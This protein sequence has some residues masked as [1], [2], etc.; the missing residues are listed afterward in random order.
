[1]RILLTLS[2]GCIATACATGQT[3]SNSPVTS[4]EILTTE[5]TY[6]YDALRALRPRWLRR[7]VDAPEMGVARRRGTPLRPPMPRRASQWPTWAKK[8]YGVMTFD[9]FLPSGSWRYA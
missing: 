3:A 6:A 8:A 2:I 7:T 1:M 4:A 5:A 9:A